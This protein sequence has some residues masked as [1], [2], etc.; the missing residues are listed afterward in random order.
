VGCGIYPYSI[1]T[2]EFNEK[3]IVCSG[4]WIETG[5]KFVTV[6]KIEGRTIVLNCVV[7]VRVL[8]RTGSQVCLL[9]VPT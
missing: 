9:Y 4:G 1:R 7:R 8:Y 2:V 5:K 6:T 3:L